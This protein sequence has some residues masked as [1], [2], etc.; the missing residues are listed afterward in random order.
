MERGAD[1]RTQNITGS[2]KTTFVVAGIVLKYTAIEPPGKSLERPDE[3]VPPP[4]NVLGLSG[5]NLQP[6]PI[7]NK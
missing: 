6:A 1:Q 7:A 4:P 2:E 3:K 5:C